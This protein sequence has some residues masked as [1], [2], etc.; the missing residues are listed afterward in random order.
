MIRRNL[1]KPMKTWVKKKLKNVYS[2]LSSEKN[3]T[4]KD[5]SKILYFE[6]LNGK[7]Y[8]IIPKAKDDHDVCEL[9]LPIPPVK[10]WLGYGEKKEVYLYGKVQVETMLDAVKK[11]GFEISPGNKVLDFGCG[12]GRMIRWLK[13]YSNECEIWGTDISSDHIFW[14]KKYLRPPFNFATTTTIPHLPFEDSYFD[15]IYAGSVFTHIDDLAESWLLELRRILNKNGRLFITIQEKNSIKIIQDNPLYRKEWLSA[16]INKSPMA[17]D[18]DS[19]FAII[20]GGRG[21][22]S[23]VFYDID[24]FCESVSNILKTVSVHKEIYGFQTGVVMMKN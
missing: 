19:D 7:D 8:Y 9:D 1:S 5:N 12:A 6:Y 21:V 2:E 13:P 11:S 24:Y 18:I 23:Q 20:S 4:H 10:L 16:Y 15:F 22:A 14:A 17:D 3:K